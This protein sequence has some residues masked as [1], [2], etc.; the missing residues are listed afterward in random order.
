MEN[1]ED[2]VEDCPFKTER[3]QCVIIGEKKGSTQSEKN[4]PG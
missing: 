4:S 2:K 1:V 3:R